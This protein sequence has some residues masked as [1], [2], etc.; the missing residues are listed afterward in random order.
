MLGNSPFYNRTI[1]K[2]VVAFGTLFNDITLVRYNKDG[3]IPHERYKV[4]LSYGPKEKYITRITSDPDL[5]KSIATHVPRISFEMTGMAYDPARKHMSTLQNFG[6]D[7]ETGLKTQYAPIPYDYEFSLSIYVRNTEDGTQIVEQILPFFTPEFV[8]TVDFI[9]SMGKKYDLPI[10][11]DSVSM[12]NEYEGDFSS[13]RLI[14][15]DLTFTVRGYVWPPVKSNTA[16]GLIGSYSTTAGAYGYVK[17]NIYLDTDKRDAQRLYI[18]SANG[19]NYYTTGE[20]IRVE[21]TDITGKV[22]YFSNSA[23]GLLVVGD[24]N[25]LISANDVVIGDYSNAR[26]PVKS[27][28]V[29]KLN[30]AEIIVR[31]NPLSANADDQFGFTDEY[32]E[33]PNTLF[34]AP[35][36]SY[37]VD[38]N[39]IFAD[40]NTITADRG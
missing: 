8:V 23:S 17:S 4:P 12:N 30:A 26:Y 34:D 22:I 33:W 13:T 3:N 38:S 25:K 27:L 21:N 2:I 11:L 7:H 39:Y 28:D 18:N 24:L 35:P 5:T 16:Q 10:K 9:H 15:W 29:T 1:R 36:L 31:P 20:S 32:T 19:K 40:N 37:R 14:V 6:Y